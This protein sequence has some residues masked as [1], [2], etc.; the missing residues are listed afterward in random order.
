METMRKKRKT[1]FP[2]AALTLQLFRQR[3]ITT[4][5]HKQNKGERCGDLTP[6]FHKTFQV[7]PGDQQHPDPIHGPHVLK[8]LQ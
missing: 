3:G 5:H 8:D 1:A 2:S 4:I 7:R 6:S